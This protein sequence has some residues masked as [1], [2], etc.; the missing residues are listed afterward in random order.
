MTTLLETLTAQ[1]RQLGELQEA[2]QRAITLIALPKAP[3]AHTNGNGVQQPARARKRAW[4]NDPAAV[5]R[6]KSAIA[7][8]NRA[9]WAAKR[10]TADEPTT[11]TTE[12]E[13]V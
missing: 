7:A 1:L 5:R 9:H 13:T 2:T 11:I 4:M 12:T 6:W 10:R 8:G 3:K